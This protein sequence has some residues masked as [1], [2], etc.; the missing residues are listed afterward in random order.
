MHCRGIVG[1]SKHDGLARNRQEAGPV[2]SKRVPE[3]E[4]ERRQTS[5]DIARPEA[6]SFQDDHLE[7]LFGEMAEIGREHI[8]ED[9]DLLV[10]VFGLEWR[11]VRQFAVLCRWPREDSLEATE[12][13]GFDDPFPRHD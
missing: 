1:G 4:G 11:G 12:V 5:I 6:S 8:R 10:D 7:E 9:A 2:Q 13:P 3:L